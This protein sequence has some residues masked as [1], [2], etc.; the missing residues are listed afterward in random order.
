MTFSILAIELIIRWNSIS[1]VYT[2]GSTGQVIPFTIGIGGLIKVLS[3]V[4]AQAFDNDSLW[5]A[6]IEAFRMHNGKWAKFP[7]KAPARRRSWAGERIERVDNQET[8]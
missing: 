6:K 3:T 7:V 2:I 5:S 4:P 8:A 1:G